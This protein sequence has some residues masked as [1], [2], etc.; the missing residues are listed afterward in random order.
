MDN[1]V[2]IDRIVSALKKVPPKTL[3]I[4]ELANT[5]PI[6]YGQ[7]DLEVLK[8]KRKEI[9]LAEVEAKA[10]GGATIQAVSSLSR[11]KS[12]NEA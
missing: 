5:I 12:L 11:C 3:L 7:P 4:I 2:D 1:S 6:V 10:Y 8:A 9:N